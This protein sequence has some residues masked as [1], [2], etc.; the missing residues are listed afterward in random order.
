MKTQTRCREYQEGW[1]GRRRTYKCRECSK[2]FQV[3]TK[4]SLPEVRRICPECKQSNSQ[5]AMMVALD[6]GKWR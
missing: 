3:D 6:V 5:V 2:K 4:E 1:T